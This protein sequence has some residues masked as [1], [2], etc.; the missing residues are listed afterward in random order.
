MRHTE[1]FMGRVGVVDELKELPNNNCVLNFSVA[2]TIRVKEGDNWVDGPTIWTNVTIFGDEARNLYRSVRPGT[3]VL[4]AGE[5]RAR[6]YTPKDSTEKRLV[7]SVIAQH[8]GVCITKF[9]YVESIGNV[10]YAKEGYSVS[11]PPAVNTS[12]PSQPAN[13]SKPK[14]DPFAETSFGED[15]FNDDDPFGLNS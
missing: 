14:E 8:V 1:T 5:R 13:K 3:F 4:V 12:K 7:Q 2:E 15:S 9:N 6:E 11:P 10:N